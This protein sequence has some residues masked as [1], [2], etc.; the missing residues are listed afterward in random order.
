MAATALI[1]FTQGSPGPNGEAVFGVVSS[2]VSIANVNNTD[3][4]SWRIELTYAPPGSS[5]E[6]SPGTPTILA[7]A[8]SNT[9]AA[10]FTPDQ[11]GSYRI[12]LVVYAATGQTGQHNEDIRVFSVPTTKRGIILP[13]FQKL[14]DPL[15]LPASGDPTAKPNEM[16]FSGQEYGWHGDNAAGLHKFLK[17]ADNG[18][19]ASI[20]STITA[21][22]QTASEGF[23]PRVVP[24]D[25]S[26]GSWPVSTGTV[27]IGAGMPVGHTLMIV[28][29][30]GQAGGTKPITV[31]LA[32]GETVAGL[33]SFKINRNYASATLVK[34]SSSVWVFRGA[35][36]MKES[37]VLVGGLEATQL[38]GFTTRGTVSIDTA[39]YPN[40]LS[41]T[42]KVV[43]E[44][45]DA[46]DPAQMRLF[47]YTTTST[48]ATLTTPGAVGPKFLS[49][50][51]TLTSG[52]NI[53]QAQSRLTVSGAPTAANLW[54]AWIEILWLLP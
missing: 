25:T 43:L 26:S 12:R 28:D 41:A 2:I 40:L 11:V 34:V 14:P 9:P 37:I 23:S 46:D 18:A 52:A 4:A 31:N 39:D 30:G 49:S 7:Q 20:H 47:N 54:S 35:K 15:P 1:K 42:L 44:T 16:N 24:I 45:T 27:T 33:S 10:T 36:T 51:I 17:D 38:L 13:P 53:Y 32:G 22:A 19:L 29:T 3:V 5:L 6:V 48:I 8:D 21:T 50:A